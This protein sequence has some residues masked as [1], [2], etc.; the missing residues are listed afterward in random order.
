MPDFHELASPGIKPPLDE[1]FSPASII[2]REFLRMSDASGDRVPLTIAIERGS[3]QVSVYNT[4]CFG[5]DNPLSACYAERTVKMLLWQRGGWRIMISGPE[6]VCG[7]IKNTYST[8][9]KRKFD[10]EFMS[11]VYEKEFTVEC[12]QPEDMPDPKESVMPLGGHLDGCRIGFDLGASDRKVSA[13]IDGEPVYTEEVNWD[14]RNATD[15]SYH[16]K[17]LTAALKSAASHMPRVDAIGGS[18]AGIYIDNRP[19]VASLFRGIPK[20]LFDS[21]IATL[22]TTLREDWGGIPFEVV[23]DG[24]VTALAGSMSLND[25]AVLGIALGSSEAGGYVTENRKITTWLNEL[26]FCPVDYSPGAAV[27]EWSGDSGCGSQYFSQQA[28]F[29]LAKKAGIEIDEA[30]GLAE[31]LA[32]VQEFLE[33]GDERALKIWE[34]IGV[35]M[36]YGIAHYAD[37]Y[38]IKHALILGRVTSGRGGQIILDGAKRVLEAD[39]PALAA[40]IDIS[41]PDESSRRVGQAVAAASLPAI[42]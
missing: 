24:E 36:G 23:N 6:A 22:F 19:R 21:R 1:N 41:L 25:G 27:D 12:L 31:R 35:Y 18:S 33:S 38:N 3:G 28:V 11:G 15:P 2:D 17:E 16:Y 30:Q 34:T 37:F 39:F 29:R 20:D 32:H 9:G 14:P 13:V 5:A 7:H 8:G 26:A 42:V 4:H 40:N 10:A